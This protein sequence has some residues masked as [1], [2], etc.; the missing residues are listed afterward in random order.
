MIN[1]E[2]Q[3]IKDWYIKEYPE[4]ECGKDMIDNITFYN[5]F[6]ALDRYKDIYTLIGI[7]DSLI[8]ERIFEKLSHIM[9]V[10]YDYIYSQWLIAE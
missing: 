4:D 5:V 6:E 1:K 9:N 8:R 10:S 2:N 3:N 7:S